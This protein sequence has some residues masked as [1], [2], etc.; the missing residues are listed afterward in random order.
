MAQT[1]AGYGYVCRTIEALGID[2]GL[3]CTRY[4]LEMEKKKDKDCQRKNSLE[5]KKRRNQLHTK[6]IQGIARKE[7]HE[8]KTYET[9]VGLNID[10]TTGTIKSKKFLVCL[11]TISLWKL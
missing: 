7:K 11:M 5:F 1:N 4:T 8:G 2:L 9:N 3:T 10:Q 6:R